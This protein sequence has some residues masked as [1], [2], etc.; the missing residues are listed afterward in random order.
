MNVRK[1]GPIVTNFLLSWSICFARQ[2]RICS[3]QTITKTKM[4]FSQFS[5]FTHEK[6]A[7]P[8]DHF[9]T[10]TPNWWPNFNF[11]KIYNLFSSFRNRK[12]WI[13]FHLDEIECNLLRT[14]FPRISLFFV[15]FPSHHKL[16]IQ[17]TINI[18]LSPLR[19]HRLYAHALT[20]ATPNMINFCLAV[21][22]P[23]SVECRTSDNLFLSN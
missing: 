14:F 21:F 22:C 7:F 13:L 3:H 8:I 9:V 11:Q 18:S 12:K 20:K 2:F 1:C 6:N 19:S 5:V 10:C 16:F 17:P 23:V 4:V 15:D